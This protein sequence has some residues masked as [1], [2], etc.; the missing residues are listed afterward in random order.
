[1]VTKEEVR[2]T[3]KVESNIKLK[4]MDAVHGR[5]QRHQ[6]WKSHRPNRTVGW[7]R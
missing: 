4:P 1:M 2:C 3:I 6:S 7:R 5:G